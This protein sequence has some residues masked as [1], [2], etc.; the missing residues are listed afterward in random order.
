MSNN[1]IPCIDCITLAVCKAKCDPESPNS[2][3]LSVVEL[4][5]RCPLLREYIYRADRGSYRLG[6]TSEYFAELYSIQV[7]EFKIFL[8]TS[9][10]HI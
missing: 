9:N 3:Y 6:K 7:E 5:F 2:M 10:T 8:P 1:K 4:S